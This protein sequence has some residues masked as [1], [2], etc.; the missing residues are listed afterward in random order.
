MTVGDAVADAGDLHGTGLWSLTGVQP[1]ANVG[2]H[3]VVILKPSTEAK[4]M[5][6]CRIDIHGTLVARIAHG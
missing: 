1:V 2:E 5:V 4:A 3:L 6:T